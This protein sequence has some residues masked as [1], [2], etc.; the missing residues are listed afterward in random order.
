MSLSTELLFPQFH[1]QKQ[2]VLLA[3]EWRMLSTQVHTRS[4][5]D[6]SCGTGWAQSVRLLTSVCLLD[7]GKEHTL[8]SVF[9]VFIPFLERSFFKQQHLRK[10]I[11]LSSGLQCKDPL[12]WNKP[13]WSQ[14]TSDERLMRWLT[15]RLITHLVRDKLVKARPA[16]YYYLIL[17]DRSLAWK[18]IKH[19]DCLPL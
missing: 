17:G 7:E 3:G 5:Q 13:W 12:S 16:C 15:S 4:R 14:Y 6:P 19:C 18:C 2:S 1:W 8:P 10:R 9:K 11:H